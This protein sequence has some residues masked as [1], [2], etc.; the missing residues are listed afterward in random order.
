[1]SA[2]WED[3]LCTRLSIA[4]NWNLDPVCEGC[5]PVPEYLW[6]E[7]S[8]CAPWMASMWC[9]CSHPHLSSWICCLCGNSRLLRWWPSYGL[10]SKWDEDGIEPHP[11]ASSSYPWHHWQGQQAGSGDLQAWHLLGVMNSWCQ[12]GVSCDWEEWWRGGTGG[13]SIAMARLYRQE[14]E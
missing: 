11:L 5:V 2:S 4:W 14:R 12:V 3:A 10:E 8:Q 13:D 7:N 9:S 1:M 6:G